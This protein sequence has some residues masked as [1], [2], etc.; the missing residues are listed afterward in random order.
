M[1]MPAVFEPVSVTELPFPHNPFK[2]AHF[3]RFRGLDTKARR[4]RFRLS[5][6]ESKREVEQPFIASLTADDIAHCPY[7]QADWKRIADESIRIIDGLGRAN[8]FAHWLAAAQ[9]GLPDRDRRWLE[10]LFAD[11]IRISKDTYTNGQQ[12]GCA[13]RFSG[14][15]RAAVIVAK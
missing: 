4:D 12:R 6:L 2:C 3:D 1:S 5:A 7:H 9:S 10:S 14:A 11:P 13:L 15:T 8:T